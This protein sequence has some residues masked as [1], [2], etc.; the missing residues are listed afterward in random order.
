MKRIDNA[1][2]R[3]MVESLSH[4]HDH[5]IPKENDLNMILVTVSMWM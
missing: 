1:M 2:R 5:G 4:E 3:I